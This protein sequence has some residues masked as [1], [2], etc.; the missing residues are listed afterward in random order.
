MYFTNFQGFLA[1]TLIDIF[2]NKVKTINS[3]VHGVKNIVKGVKKSAAKKVAK[4]IEGV[5]SFLYAFTKGVTHF[6]Y[7]IADNCGDYDKHW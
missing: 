6:L 2:T 3:K 5:G 7:W 4:K 1:S